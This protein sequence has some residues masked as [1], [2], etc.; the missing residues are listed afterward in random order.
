[1]WSSK[2]QNEVMTSTA[3]AKYASIAQAMKEATWLQSL[4]LELGFP[5]REP[6]IIFGNNQLALAICHNYQ[7]HLRL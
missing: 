4:F 3:K 6:T 1:M 7:Y 2:K 5:L